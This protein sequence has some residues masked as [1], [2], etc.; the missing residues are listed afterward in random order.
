MANWGRRRRIALQALAESHLFAGDVATAC[1]YFEEAEAFA[2]KSGYGTILAELHADL[3]QCNFLDG[4]V[5]LA[6]T[7][8]TQALAEPEA[9]EYGIGQQWSHSLLAR[10]CT[11]L[12]RPTEA[13][14]HQAAADALCRQTGY[15]PAEQRPALW[16]GAGGRPALGGGATG[17]MGG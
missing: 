16:A 14:T 6:Y 15:T 4:E 7:Q 9:I 2:T 11:V 17:R 13:A 8:A 5:E 10:C 3:A 1:T 12:N